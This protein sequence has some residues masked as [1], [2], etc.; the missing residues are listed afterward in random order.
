MTATT[1]HNALERDGYVIVEGLLTPD[2]VAA[3]R[4][5]LDPLLAETPFGAN[6]FVGRTTKRVFGLP[7]KTRVLDTLVLHPTVL[8]AMDHLLG[9]YTLS[10]LVA[11]E[12]H[13][14][15]R[16][17]SPHD[18]KDAWPVP[19]GGGQILVNAIWALDDFTAENG[20]TT[21]EGV[22]PVEMPAGSALIYTGS[23]RHGGGANT[24][25]HPRLAIIAGYLVSW[26]RQQENFT[27]T[28]PPEIARTTPPRMQELLGYRMFPPFVGHTDGRDP[29]ELLR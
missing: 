21:I 18:D 22:G 26:I 24:S 7:A 2:E 6:S 4:A 11:V 23:V 15:E 19:P 27:L 5:E 3:I 13:P 12:I 25:D 8:D 28:C 14:G 16:A 9:D 1:L 17:Q 10:T 20:A 29:M